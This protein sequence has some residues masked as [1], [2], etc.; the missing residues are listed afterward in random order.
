[1]DLSL[2]SIIVAILIVAV[3]VTLAVL[4]LR[5]LAANSERRMRSMIER[6]GVDIENATQDEID[7]II[8][9]VRRR[10][11]KCRSEDVCERWLTGE[12]K[13]DNSFCPN[14][15]IFSN[16]KGAATHTA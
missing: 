5:Y 12:I 14:A 1:M 2:P 6:C 8:K 15:S 13:G 9:D 16:L 4:Y 3:G 11:R 7:A 10:C